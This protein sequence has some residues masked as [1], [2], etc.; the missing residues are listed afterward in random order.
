MAQPQRTKPVHVPEGG[1][2]QVALPAP[3]ILAELGE[4]GIFALLAAFYVRLEMTELRPWFP[5]DMHEASEHSAAFFVQLMGGRPL[6]VER[7]GPPRM[8]MRHIPFEIDEPARRIWLEAFHAT[9]AAA[10]EKDEF[11]AGARGQLPRFPGQLLRVDG[12]RGANG[13]VT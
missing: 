2:P 5:E 11:P 1:P 9:I 7:F 3:E 4:D 13:A 10:I 12:E 6:F 8:R